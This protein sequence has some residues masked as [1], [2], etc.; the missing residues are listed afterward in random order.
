[1]PSRFTFPFLCLMLSSI[2][3]VAAPPADTAH[4]VVIWQDGVES[5]ILEPLADPAAAAACDIETSCP[6]TLLVQNLGPRVS[7]RSRIY[8]VSRKGLYRFTVPSDEYFHTVLS[9][10]G[11][12]FPPLTILSALSNLH[13]HGEPSYPIPFDPQL[14][15]STTPYAVLTCGSIC[16]LA[17]RIFVSLQS[18]GLYRQLALR[19]INSCIDASD[20]PN[21]YDDGH[22]MLEFSNGSRH[23]VLFDLD[24]GLVFRDRATGELMDA[25]KFSTAIRKNVAPELVPIARKVAPIDPLAKYG[26]YFYAP[27]F[28]VRWASDARRWE[29]YRRSAWIISDSQQCPPKESRKNRRLRANN[30][31]LAAASRVSRPVP[32]SWANVP[33]DPQNF[34]ASAGQWTVDAGDQA[35]FAFTLIGKTMIVNLI[36]DY[37]SV[38]EPAQYLQVKIPGE[39]AAVS[40]Q[41]GVVWTKDGDRPWTSSPVMIYGDKIHFARPDYASPWTKSENTTHVRMTFTFETQ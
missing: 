37:T 13:I 22:V 11:D 18:E 1:M 2:P 38:A 28:H 7:F 35:R 15:V 32:G 36:L 3:A 33:Y 16:A 14:L 41:D 23:W 29:W 39:F 40:Q 21:G 27:E 19:M 25:K 5:A 6:Q 34:T 20:L 4:I 9:H 10:P 8:D 30:A 17:S 26:G 24:G 31:E 12:E